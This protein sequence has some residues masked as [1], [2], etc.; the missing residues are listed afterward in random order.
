M[1]YF[2]PYIQLVSVGFGAFGDGNSKTGT[3]LRKS[4]FS[5]YFENQLAYDVSPALVK[6]GGAFA[7]VSIPSS[8]SPVKCAAANSMTF[9]ADVVGGWYLAFALIFESVDMPFRL[10]LGDLSNFLRRKDARPAQSTT[11]NQDDFATVGRA[12]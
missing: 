12:T 4:F 10:P 7:F 2:Y 8:P 1:A 5:P 11:Q 6:A 9:Q 3:R